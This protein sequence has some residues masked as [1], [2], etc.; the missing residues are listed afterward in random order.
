METIYILTI[1]TTILSLVIATILAI[2]T[3]FSRKAFKAAL[4]LFIYSFSGGLFGAFIGSVIGLA[5]ISV[6]LL[7]TGYQGF[8]M[9]GDG[10]NL[11]ITLGILAIFLICWF[12]GTL[13]VGIKTIKPFLK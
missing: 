1:A 11:Y 10:S 6:V 13:V 9:Y 7:I 4:N 5:I 8:S 12:L 2:I 3:L